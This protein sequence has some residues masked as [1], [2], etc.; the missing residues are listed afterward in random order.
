MPKEQA[1]NLNNGSNFLAKTSAQ[2]GL[3]KGKTAN[4][5]KKRE[6]AALTH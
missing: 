5:T 3:K 6:E 4:S 2:P 1:A